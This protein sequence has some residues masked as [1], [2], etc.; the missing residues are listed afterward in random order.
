MPPNTRILTDQ[1]DLSMFYR[2]ILPDGLTVA[3]QVTA[4][5]P[6]VA[7]SILG[8]VTTDYVLVTVLYPSMQAWPFLRTYRPDIAYIEQKLGIDRRRADL[9]SWLLPA[10][11][12]F[13]PA[14]LIAETADRWFYNHP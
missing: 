13:A 6:D 11:T 4:L 8:T 9:M 14:D 10:L 2:L 5:T 3:V 12:R 1:T 7:K